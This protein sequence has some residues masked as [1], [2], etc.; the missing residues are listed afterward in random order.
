MIERQRVEKFLYFGG[1][2][3]LSD[4]NHVYGGLVATISDKSNNVH[5]MIPIMKNGAVF[6]R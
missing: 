1:M 2:L 4:S 3:G 6:G 5:V